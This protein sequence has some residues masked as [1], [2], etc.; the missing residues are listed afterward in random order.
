MTMEE[1]WYHHKYDMWDA[2]STT[3][4]WVSMEEY[5]QDDDDDGAAGSAFTTTTT[6]PPGPLPSQ[7][8]RE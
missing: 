7:V 2:K 5:W 8:Q 1:Y 4:K 3:P 6:G